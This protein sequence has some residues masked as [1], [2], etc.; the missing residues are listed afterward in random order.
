MFDKSSA[1]FPIKAGRIDVNHCGIAPMYAGAAE[2]EQDCNE[3]RVREGVLGAAG[4]GPVL[5][6]LH[7]SAA[8]LLETDATNISFMKNAAEGLSLIAFGYPFEHGDEVISYVH[9]YPSN[10]YPWRLQEARGAVLK[11]LPDV[12]PSGVVGEG[13]PRGWSLN[14]LEAL[15]TPRTRVL[16]ISHVQFTS[17]FAA[18]LEAVG[19]FCHDRGIDLIIDAAQSLG[20]LPVLPE[21]WHIA[22]VACSGWKWLMGAIG[23]GLL[24]TSP[25]LRERLRIVMAGADIVTQG[26]D[27]LNH[28]WHPHSDGRRSSTA[29]SPWRWP[30][31]WTAACGTFL[32][33]VTSHRSG[34][35]SFASGCVSIAPRPDASCTC[36]VAGAEPLRHSLPR[37]RGCAGTCPPSHGRKR[38]GHRPRRLPA[39]CAAFLQRR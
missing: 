28:T 5:R 13:R 10:H 35:R 31:A 6:S 15:V 20:C 32:C 11:L 33:P 39:R 23:C 3:A 12:D 8:R 26:D 38:D 37:V 14:N 7:E 21:R 19:Q 4:Y 18:D 29:R 27:Y 22:A 2:A 16:A 17:G 34:T 36:C 9:E 1:R 24:Y 30:P 25:A